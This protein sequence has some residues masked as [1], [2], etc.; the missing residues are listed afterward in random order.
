VYT[1]FAHNV[2]SASPLLAFLLQAVVVI[3]EIGLGLAFVGGAF[4]W[5]AAVVSILI[6]VMFIASGWGSPELL[7]YMFGALVMMGGAG[8]AL[9]LD[10]WI[11][12]WL[13]GWWNGTRF[14]KRTYLYTD[15][16]HDRW[17]GKRASRPQSN[18][19]VSSR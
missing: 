17:N 19:S 13:K 16:P 15:E 12:P 11:M 5:L 14:A 18:I 4:T 8:R 7:W 9:G 1:W 6:G 2:L 10:H 3:V